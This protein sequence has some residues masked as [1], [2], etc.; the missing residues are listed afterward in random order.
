MSRILRLIPTALATILCFCLCTLAQAPK[1][2][3]K[4]AEFIIG[5]MHIQTVGPIHYLYGSAETTLQDLMQPI[6]RFL[7]GL[8]QAASEGKIQVNG[9]AVFI[10][11]NAQPE[12]PFTIDIGFRVSEQT[13]VFGE[14]KLRKTE[15]FHCATVLYTGPVSQIIKAYDKLIQSIQAAGLNPGSESREFYLFW[16]GPD[17]PNNV[18][19]IQISLR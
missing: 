5:E 8:E 13:K 6:G 3:P 17:S 11:H 1:P 2:S 9:P 14:Y 16:E 15:P 4:P 18:V 12:K 7:P 19:Q 10:Y